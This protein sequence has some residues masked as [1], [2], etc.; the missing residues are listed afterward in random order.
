MQCNFLSHIG[1]GPF[2]I[3][4]LTLTNACVQMQQL[5]EILVIGHFQYSFHKRTMY[6]P[7]TLEPGHSA[8]CLSPKATDREFEFKNQYF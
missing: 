7:C 5:A 6:K 2:I 1:R 4:P 8:M 3:A